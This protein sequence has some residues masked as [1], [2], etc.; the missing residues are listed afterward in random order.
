[1]ILGIILT[2]FDFKFNK[3][4]NFCT[5]GTFFSPQWNPGIH[6]LLLFPLSIN[7]WLNREKKVDLP[8]HGEEKIQERFCRYTIAFRIGMTFICPDI[9][10]NWPRNNWPGPFQIHLFFQ[11]SCVILKV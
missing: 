3:V 4:L 10:N 9:R 5:P 8:E 1:L 11:F 2:F 7:G 6:T